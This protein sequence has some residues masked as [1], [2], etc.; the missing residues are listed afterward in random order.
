MPPR[1]Y[2]DLA[3]L[4][5]EEYRKEAEKR[6]GSERNEYRRELY[7]KHRE[8]ILLESKNKRI[9]ERIEKTKKKLQEL[10]EKKLNVAAEQ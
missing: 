1:K 10:E 8:T 6:R 2:P 4:S 5:T 7:Q 3:H 9:A